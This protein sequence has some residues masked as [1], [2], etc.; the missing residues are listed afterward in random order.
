[1]KELEYVVTFNYKV[2]VTEEE[3]LKN[4]SDEEF[5]LFESGKLN[6]DIINER[7]HQLAKLEFDKTLNSIEVEEFNYN[8][9]KQK[10]I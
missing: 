4:L 5:E 10:S 3:L 9:K 6:I 8:I 1:M 2:T 7:V